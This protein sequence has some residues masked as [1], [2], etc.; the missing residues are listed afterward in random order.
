MK[1]TF[2]NDELQT[3]YTGG[4][5]SSK[6]FKSNPQVV[7]QFIKTVNLLKGA[8]RI[9]QLT[10]FKSL[11]YHKLDDDRIG[12]SSV[13]VNMQYRLIFIEISSEEP[14]HEIELLRIEE[15]TNHYN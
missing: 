3:L 1:I 9:E 6:E 4:K 15:L 8:T 12:Q 7:K 13:S 14:P 5:A 11:R 10:Q 2:N